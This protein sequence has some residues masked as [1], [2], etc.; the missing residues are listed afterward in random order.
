[1][2]DQ[3]SLAVREDMRGRQRIQVLYLLQVG[4]VGEPIEVQANAVGKR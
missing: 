3:A 1:M 4:F 2:D